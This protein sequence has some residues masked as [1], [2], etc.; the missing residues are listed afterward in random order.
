MSEQEVIMNEYNAEDI[1]VLKG[2]EAVRL[3]PG[4]YIGGV[5]TT[6][7]HHLVFELVDNSIDETLAGYC[8]EIDVTIH[9]DGSIS[10]QD[11]GR[12]IPVGIHEEENISALQLIMTTLHA[13]GK[14]DNSNYKISGG[15]NGVGASVVNAL[16]SKLIVEVEREGYFW[17]QEYM[18]G[19][20]VA[21]LQQLGPSQ[22]T[23]T[24]TTFWPDTTIFY[25]T[26]FHF[27][28]LSQRLRELAFF[29]SW[30]L[31]FHS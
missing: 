28:I 16:S 3:R 21:D 9:H 6:A 20:A 8:N 26:E 7:L 10:V 13:G 31:H 22:K 2:L 18:K 12:G 17:K 19:V 1:T 29:K 14:F 4:M 11:N 25:E 5:D 24:N 27:E 15:L 30:H 23:G